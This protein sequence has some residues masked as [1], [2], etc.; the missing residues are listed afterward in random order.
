MTKVTFPS[1]TFNYEFKT[2]KQARQEAIRSFMNMINDSNILNE[3]EVVKMKDPCK[4]CPENKCRN[5]PVKKR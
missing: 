5:C 4:N 2:K 3:I 1:I